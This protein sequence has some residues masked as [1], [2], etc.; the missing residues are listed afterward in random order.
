MS[1][2]YVHIPFCKS[3]CIYCGFFSTTSLE[4][5]DVYVDA[6]CAEISLRRDYLKGE[7]VETIYFGGGTPSMLSH[8][9]IDK[10]LS[11]IYKIY[12]VRK[13]AEITLEGNPDD[14]TPEF[15]FG[16]HKMGFNRLSMGIQSFSD[17]TLRFL[18][19]RHSASQAVSAIHDAVN[20]GFR[21]ISVDLMFGFPNQTLEAHI[22]LF[23]DV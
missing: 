11:V 3:R 22:S 20:V 10:I 2:I 15:L 17:R 6:V 21:N 18:H 16:L 14:L 5:R 19:R 13:D 12:K 7:D 9:Q 23:L 8:Q 4:K 1:G